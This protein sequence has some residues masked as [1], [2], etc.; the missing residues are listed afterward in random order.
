MKTIP[1]FLPSGTSPIDAGPGLAG[2]GAGLA[3]THTAALAGMGDYSYKNVF[4]NSIGIMYMLARYYFRQDIPRAP[5]AVMGGIPLGTVT[6]L[7]HAISD[8]IVRYRARG[9][10]FLAHQ[11]GGN[12][13]LR[14][15]GQS[16]GA[17]RYIFLTMLQMLFLSGM[18]VEKDLHQKFQEGKKTI[19]D[20]TETELTENPWTVF[21]I[22]NV[23]QGIEEEHMTFPVITKNRVYFSMYIET[24]EYIEKIENGQ[25]LVEYTI[26][27]RKY[28]PLPEYEYTN[29][30]VTDPRTGKDKTL[31]VYRHKILDKRKSSTLRVVSLGA[32]IGLSAM[33]QADESFRRDAFL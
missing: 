22:D 23:D 31:T 33:V 30:E 10:I 4:S 17:N 16:W 26:F 21:E 9:G 6:E 14:I 1:K 27:F 3:L 11:D 20:F 5:S 13:S 29:I 7:S 2:L 8:R 15:V 12:E 25:K 28:D 32:E 24:F 19:Q 18:D